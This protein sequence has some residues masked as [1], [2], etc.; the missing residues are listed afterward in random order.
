[1]GELELRFTVLEKE[2]RVYVKASRKGISIGNLHDLRVAYKKMDTLMIWALT[3]MSPADAALFSS[4]FAK[5]KSL[6]KKAGKVRTAQLMLRTGAKNGLWEIS[7]NVE[8]HL[9]EKLEKHTQV[10]SSYVDKFRF[11][12]SKKVYNAIVRYDSLTSFKLNACRRDLIACQLYEARVSLASASGEHW[13]YA[14][15]LLKSSVYLMTIGKKVGDRVFSISELENWSRLEAVLGKWHDWEM[16]HRFLVLQPDMEVQTLA[17]V[18]KRI[19]EL[20]TEV[21]QKTPKAAPT[22]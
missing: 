21:R 2:L 22:Q 12:S 20:E 6:Y 9:L 11:P 13:H 15:R 17:F 3:L 5:L 16:L 14:R 8:K 18:R 1:M 19:D 4:W 7:P 10:Y